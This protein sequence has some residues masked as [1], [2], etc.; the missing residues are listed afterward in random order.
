MTGEGRERAIIMILTS[1]IVMA[2]L[3]AGA[4]AA[5][6]VAKE[7]KVAVFIKEEELAL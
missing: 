2:I 7:N 4:R 1:T 6:P 3:D 5:D